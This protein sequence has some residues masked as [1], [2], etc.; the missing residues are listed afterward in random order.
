MVEF[1]FIP[2]DSVC[3]FLKQEDVWSTKEEKEYQSISAFKK[4]EAHRIA[5]I[6]ILEITY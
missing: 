5:C 3:L 4:L 2:S 1:I 6:R